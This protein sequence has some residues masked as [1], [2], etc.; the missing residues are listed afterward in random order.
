MFTYVIQIN[1]YMNVKESYI[2]KAQG[3]MRKT[4]NNQDKKDKNI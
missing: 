3:S 2:Y 1:Y 4:K